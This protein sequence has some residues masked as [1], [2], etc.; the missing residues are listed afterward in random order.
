MTYIRFHFLI[1]CFLAQSTFTLAQFKTIQLFNPQTNDHTPIIKMGE[2]LVFS[3]DELNKKYQNYD[4]RIVRFDRNWQPSSAFTSEFL[5]GSQRNRIQFHKSSFYTRVNYTHYEVKFPNNDFSLKLSGNYAIQVLKSGSDQVLFEKR[6]YLVEP[7]AD[8]GVSTERI[9][10]EKINNQRVAVVI[11]SPSIDFIQSNDYEVVIMQNNNP[12]VSKKLESPTFSH[13]HQLIY[14][15]LNTN[16]AGGAEFEFFDTKN[17]DLAGMTTQN[18]LRDNI[19]NVFLYRV[20]YSENSVYNDQPDLDGDYYIRNV[21][22][23]PQNSAFEADYA[24]IHFFLEDFEPKGQEKPCVVG[25]F[26][27]FSCT[28]DSVLHFNSEFDVW[29]TKILLKQGYYNYSFATQNE[30]QKMDFSSII[31]SHW[32]TENKYSALLYIKP[33]GQRYDLLIG[34]GEGYSKP[35]YR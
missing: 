29:E 16:F 27:N 35:P 30:E 15:S 17:I 9:N 14:K 23:S 28:E 25:A 8:V 7:L 3:F 11:N 34:Y 5:E 2:Y 12:K 21:A 22:S 10:S 4:Y 18:I 13:S 24:E 31:G 20:S 1:L 33:W 26:N 19:Y 32:Q 6:F